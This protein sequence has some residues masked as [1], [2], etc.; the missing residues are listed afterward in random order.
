[1]PKNVPATKFT[2]VKALDR[3]SHVVHEMKCLFRLI[4]QDEFGI[5]GEIE[6]VTPKPDGEGFQTS[7]G[8]IKVQAKSVR[9]TSRRMTAGLCH[10]RSD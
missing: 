8:I 9:V 6:V 5:D 3:I 10:A 4:S 2:E 1:M 7:G